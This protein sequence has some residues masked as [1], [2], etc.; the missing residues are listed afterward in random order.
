VSISPDESFKGADDMTAMNNPLELYKLLNKSN[1]R[2]CM[3]PSCMAFAVAVIQGRKNIGDCPEFD[4]RSAEVLSGRIT[5]RKNMVDEQ[6][7]NLTTL[8]QEVARVD[9]SSVAK[10]LG[11]VASRGSLEISCLGKNFVIDAAGEMTSE[12]HKN[13]WLHVPLLNYII[14]GSG[15]EL[16]GDLVSFGEL[17]G[18]ADWSRFFS[19]RCEAAMKQLADVHGELFFEILHLF[20][21]RTVSGLDADHSLVIHPLP[22]VPFV[23]NYWEAEQGFGSKLNILFDKT[24]S[25]NLKTESIYLLG[26]GLIEMFRAIIVKH[27]K[28]G[29]LL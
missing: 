4:A 10:R 23:I 7:E 1:C 19:H 29:Q 9:F 28:D 26:R 27:S 3:L 8:K 5:T 13:P 25:D 15:K 6:Q 11:A 22:K 12:C 16:S 2:K 20:G 17:R 18:A 14:F 21:A 24:A